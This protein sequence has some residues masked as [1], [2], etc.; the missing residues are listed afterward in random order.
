MG[1]TKKE[2]LTHLLSSQECPHF[3]W[4]NPEKI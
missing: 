2:D 4:E 1:W 3:L